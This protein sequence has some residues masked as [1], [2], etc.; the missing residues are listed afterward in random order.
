VLDGLG[1]NRRKKQLLICTSR[2][3]SNES[4]RYNA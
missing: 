4:A 2:L 3:I 1:Y